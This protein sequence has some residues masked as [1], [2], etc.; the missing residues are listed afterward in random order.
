MPGA[1]R[2]LM[3]TEA[4]A[5]PRKRVAEE[6]MQPDM[7]SDEDLEGGFED[8]ERSFEDLEQGEDGADEDDA[9]DN[10]AE[11]QAKEKHVASAYAI[12]THDEVHGLKET[13]ELFMNNLFKLQLDEMM[14]HLRPSTDHARPMELALRRLYAVVTN[15]PRIEALPLSQAVAALERRVG[16]SVQ[17]PFAEAAPHSDPAYKFAFER[18]NKLDLVGS[19]PLRAAARRAGDMDV[20]VEVQ[21]PAELFQEKDTFNMRYF[22]K[23]A[24]YLAVLAE[25]IVAADGDAGLNVDVSYMDSGADRRQTCLVLRPRRDKSE[26]DFT[27]LRAVIRVHVAH[28]LGTFPVARLAPNRNSIRGALADVRSEEELPPTPLY[29]TFVLRDS[30]RLAHLVFLHG[31]AQQCAGF[32]EACQLLKTWAAQRGFG[33]LLVPNVAKYGARRIVAG[34]D[35]ARF[36]LSMVLAHLIHGEPAQA[37]RPRTKLS[38]GM[39]SIQ[40]LR[41][42]LD[43]LGKRPFE[44]PVAM[45]AQPRWGLARHVDEESLEAFRVFDRALIE[46]SGLV[47]LLAAWPASSVDLLCSEAAQAMRMLNDADGDPFAAMFLVPATSPVARFDEVAR[48]VLPASKAHGV[49][50]MDWGSARAFGTARMLRVA[51]RALG[52]RARG[53]AACY[54]ACD[55]ASQPYALGEAPS[56]A[57]RAELGV[58]LDAVHAWHQVEHGPPP[59]APDAP[60]FRSFWGEVAELRRF[61]D[62]RVLESVVWPIATLAQRAALPRRVLRHALIHHG[63]VAAPKSIAFVGDAFAG[64]LEPAPALAARAYLKDPA[65]LGFQPLQTAYDTLTRELRAMDELP[66][67]VIGVVPVAPA[68]RSM[69]VVAPGALDLGALGARVPDAAAHL[70]VHDVLLTMESSGQWPDDLAAIQEMKT[71]LYERMAAVL[72]GRLPGATARVV[73]DVD[74]TPGETIADQTS[75]QLTLATGF[76]FGLRIHHDREHMLLQRLQRDRVARRPAFAALTRYETRFVRAPAHHLAL[77]ALQDQNPA[78]GTT[79]RLVKRWF[80]AQLLSQVPEEALELLC[81]AVF[82][83]AAHAP[84]TTGVHGWARVLEMLASWDWREAPL[85]VPLDAAARHSQAP[86]ESSAA[87][88]SVALAPAARGAAEQAFRTVRARDPGMH[89]HAWMIATDVDTTSAWTRDAP[90][91]LVADG[92]RQLA[93]RATAALAHELPVKAPS[94]RVLFAPSL[95]AYDFVVYVHAHVQM[96]YVEALEHDPARWLAPRKKR[97]ANLEDAPARESVYG[98]EPRAGFDPVREYV[99]LLEVRLRGSF[100]D[101][102]AVWRYVLPVLR[103]TRRHGNWRR[104]ERC[105][106]VSTRVQGAAGAL[107]RAGA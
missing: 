74:A 89:H 90:T 59:D 14:K 23:R 39:S 1:Q 98:S 77:Q 104:V 107:E 19:W 75:L 69:R 12:P 70:P 42:T 72:P 60:A 44:A 83:S 28:A 80:A 7:Y 52:Q 50:R 46:P 4:G 76:A 102:V 79:A 3:R 58:F 97:Y 37:G 51:R 95:G 93:A 8:L 88:G 105:A 62:G 81:A 47:N 33:A 73:Y 99:Q 82:T 71:A 17:V 9:E 63:C 56:A 92:V 94:V 26:T 45:R 40:L 53:V 85:I 49:E 13:S 32:V 78:L 54:A 66:L 36:V 38:P 10:E 67:S 24:F 101:T 87:H 20:D 30:L 18:P 5:A 84:P 48:V 2:K 103:R 43:Y 41:G 11:V 34:T 91:A 25:S 55:A 68:L 35:D 57:R 86:G 27:K 29:N 65:Q 21:M 96:R 6:E 106:I 31:T 15:I 61:R 100:T 64:L 16:R 22:H